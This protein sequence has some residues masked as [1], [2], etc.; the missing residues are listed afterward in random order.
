MILKLTPWH[1]FNLLFFVVV[2]KLSFAFLFWF[3]EGKQK[4]YRSK[5]PRIQ[6]LE[7]ICMAFCDNLYF[8]MDEKIALIAKNIFL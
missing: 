7:W 1:K 8:V 3:E 2:F 6:K 4:F 5:V